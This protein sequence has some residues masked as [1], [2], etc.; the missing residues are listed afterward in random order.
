MNVCCE[1]KRQGI[2]AFKKIPCHGRKREREAFG[3]PK[4]IFENRFQLAQ[5]KHPPTLTGMVE[6]WLEW[7]VKDGCK[8]VYM[9]KYKSNGTI[10]RFKA[11]LV[12]KYNQQNGLN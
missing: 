2:S 4:L 1:N 12:A 6:H 7:S 11:K 9:I 5:V 10:K 8:W 3:E